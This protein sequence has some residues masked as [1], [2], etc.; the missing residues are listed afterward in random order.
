MLKRKWKLVSENYKVPPDLLEK[1]GKVIAPLLLHRGIST[2]DHARM[3]FDGKH[4]FSDPYK[5]SNMQK[6]VDSIIKAIENKQKIFVYG[7]YDVDGVTATA[8]VFDYLYRKLGGDIKPY[9]PNRFDEGYGLSS[10]GLDNILEAG[11]NLVITVDCGVRDG[12]LVKEYSKK[13]LEF[14]ITDHHTP[15][16][17]NESGIFPEALAVI[18]P[19]HPET[20]VD[21]K[22]IC[23]AAVAWKLVTAISKQVTDKVNYDTNNYLDLVAM[24]TVCDVMPLVDENRNIVKQGIKQAANTDNLGLRVMADFLDVDLADLSAYH[25]GF[26]FG[27]RLNASGR[28]QD[29]MLALR[30]LTAHDEV[31]LRKVMQELE[32]LN[33]IRQDA[34]KIMLEAAEAQFAGNDHP[35]NI[36]IVAGEGWE[37]GVVGLVAGKLCEKYHKPVLAASVSQTGI[38]KGSAR[39]ISSFD[40]TAA[41]NKNAEFLQRFGG[42]KQAAG[43]TL[44]YTQFTKFYEGMLELANEMISDEDLTPVLELELNLQLKDLTMQLA[45]AIDKL[46]PF[47][48]GNKTPLFLLSK[49]K[50]VDIKNV[51]RDNS[52]I[53]LLVSQD[54][55]Q[56]GGIAFN[57]ATDF[58]EFKVGE[59]I[60]LAAGVEINVWNGRS[61]LQLKIKDVRHAD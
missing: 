8:I 36:I 41:I 39:S 37:E 18:H 49:V 31:T 17:E 46:Q 59:V 51:G 50:I 25:F 53:K 14:I 3:F 2:I 27:P 12:E 43:F 28:M 58:A 38:V 48:F 13:G 23:G 29:A 1:Y 55:K 56:I 26:I 4:E 16:K 20:E 34:T 42:H 11:G 32:D 24:A 5:F 21:F 33:K 15:A 40:V 10:E 30:L 47:G 45:E 9:I 7:D 35:D 52:H 54:N 57:M 44:E 60:D 22:D 6:A 61:N 19:Q